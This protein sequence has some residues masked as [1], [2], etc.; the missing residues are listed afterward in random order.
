MQANEKL[1]L[2]GIDAESGQYLVPPI[3]VQDAGAML[4]GDDPDTG[5]TPTTELAAQPPDPVEAS[6]LRRIWRVL[7]LPHLGLPL[8]CRSGNRRRRPAGRSCFTPTS[9]TPS[10]GRSSR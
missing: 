8:G 4:K 1:Y 2:N 7:S 6:W 3:T 9:Q 5:R 10:S